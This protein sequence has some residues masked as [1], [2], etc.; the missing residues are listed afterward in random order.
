MPPVTEHNVTPIDKNSE[1]AAG[2][3]VVGEQFKKHEKTLFR[4]IYSDRFLSERAGEA[5]NFSFSLNRFWKYSR[6]S[7]ESAYRYDIRY[8]KTRAEWFDK[9]DT[10]L[11]EIDQRLATELAR[12]EELTSP[13]TDRYE[14]NEIYNTAHDLRR[15]IERGVEKLKSDGNQQSKAQQDYALAIS[16]ALAGL[17]E[18][19]GGRLSALA[20]GKTVEL[21]TM[22]RAANELVERAAKDRI[23]DSIATEMNET[24]DFLVAFTAIESQPEQ[25]KLWGQRLDSEIAGLNQDL[26]VQKRQEALRDREKAA[27]ALEVFGA[28]LDK[29][30]MTATQKKEIVDLRIAVADQDRF[31]VAH[32]AEFGAQELQT[33]RGKRDGLVTALIDAEFK[34]HQQAGKAVIFAAENAQDRNNMYQELVKNAKTA[35][36]EDPQSCWRKVKATFLEGVEALSGR[37]LSKNFE[38]AFDSD[39]TGKFKKWNDES[40]KK[41]LNP[42][43]LQEVASDLEAIITSY[44]RRADVSVREVAA[45]AL[46]EVAAALREAGD[47]LQA[48]LTALRAVMA[49]RLR[50]L[51]VNGAFN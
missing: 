46:P 27:K 20:E 44:S 4:D 28:A 11:K 17:S 13:F 50:T 39:L 1:Q 18:Q 31:L 25:T 9:T 45:T 22:S 21:A 29:V 47:R 43:K 40:S 6:E 19:I 48:G 8:D 38:K 15:I 35:A 14:A 42:A 2:L 23:S 24:R 37:E 41:T 10:S 36:T 34:F 32:R 51:F 3:K 26:P 30:D 16:S 33:L 49:G 12:W 5:K 7:A